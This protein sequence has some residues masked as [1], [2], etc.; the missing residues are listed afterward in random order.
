MTPD[1]ANAAAGL[2]AGETPPQ[3]T[4][5]LLAAIEDGTL[6]ATGLTRL[7]LSGCGLTSLPAAIGALTTLEFLN[8][9]LIHI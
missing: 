6:A 8:L 1:E 9:S 2:Q 7:D 5:R 3:R 4:A